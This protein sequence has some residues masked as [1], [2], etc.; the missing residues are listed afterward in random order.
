M[1]R[2]GYELS[3]FAEAVEKLKAGGHTVIA[4]MIL[5]LPGENLQMMEE[6]ARYLGD[7]DIDGVKLQLLHILKGTELAQ[8]YRRGECTVMEKEEY[9][10][11][12][13]RCLQVLPRSTVIHRITGDGPADLLLAPSWSL[14]K[15]RVLNELHHYLKEEKIIQGAAYEGKE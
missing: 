11:A 3:C 15:K 6:T 8:W 13:G 14:D 10:A 7:I 9:F 4:H 5:G 1:I 2:R 12:V